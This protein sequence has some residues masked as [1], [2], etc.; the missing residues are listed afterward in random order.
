MPVRE[1]TPS[2]ELPALP[3]LRTVLVADHDASVRAGILEALERSG[4]RVLLAD[5]GQDAVDLIDQESP[6]LVLAEA[7]LPRVD[8]LELCRRIRQK[9]HSTPILLLHPHSDAEFRQKVLAAGGDGLLSR[10]VGA[11]GWVRALV[12]ALA[13]RPVREE[14]RKG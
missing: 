4:Y 11:T 9:G 1:E 2:E 10:A 8:G 13:E 14:A 7:R 6:D 12:R 5:D 3:G